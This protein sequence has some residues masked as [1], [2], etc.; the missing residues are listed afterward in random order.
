MITLKTLKDATAQEVFNQVTT[1]L[2]NQNCRSVNKVGYDGVESCMYHGNGGL[3]CAAGCLIGDD[4]YRKDMEGYDWPE[5]VD[6][7]RVPAY[8]LGLITKL[9]KVHDGLTPN[10]WVENL[11]NT[12]KEY[13]LKFNFGGEK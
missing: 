6:K 8:H 5:L 13:G 12:A 3:K 7:G 2:L 11:K 9:Q 4:E 1:H 10:M